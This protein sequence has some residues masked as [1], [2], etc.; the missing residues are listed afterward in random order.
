MA[1]AVIPFTDTSSAR[2]DNG[3]IGA[4]LPPHG[5]LRKRSADQCNNSAS[6]NGDNVAYYSGRTLY[7]KLAPLSLRRQVCPHC[8]R[9]YDIFDDN[10]NTFDQSM[11][12]RTNATTSPPSLPPPPT[13]PRLLP[14]PSQEGNAQQQQQQQQSSSSPSPHTHGQ[15]DVGNPAGLLLCSRGNTLPGFDDGVGDATNSSE[16]CMTGLHPPAAAFTSHYFRALPPPAIMA[17]ATRGVSVPLAIEDY[18]PSLPIDGTKSDYEK[19]RQQLTVAPA[20]GGGGTGDSDDSGET[21]LY[22]VSSSP[23]YSYVNPTAGTRIHSRLKLLQQKDGSEKEMPPMHESGSPMY[24]P[25]S[26]APS[27]SNGY[28][29]HYFKE[30]RQLG[31]GTYGG[32]YLCRH[33]MCGVNLGEFA[34]KKIPVGDKTTYLQSVL[35]EVRILEEVRRHPNVVEYKHSWVEEAQLA[36]FGPP[37]RCL[38]ILMEYASGGSLDTYL[39]RYGNNLSTLAVWYFFLSS[40]A[41]TAH[42]HDKHILHRDLKPQNLLLTAMQDRPPRVLVSDFGTAAVLEENLYDRSGGTGTLEYMAPE[43]FETTASPHSVNERY[44]N[45]H[46]MASD[47]WSLGMVLHYLAFDGTLP[48]RREDGSVNLDKARRSVNARPP[49]MLQLLE[50]MLQLD[51]SKRPSCSDIL[52]SSMVQSIMRI[53]NKDDYS[54]WNLSV[55]QQQQQHSAATSSSGILPLRSRYSPQA[56]GPAPRNAPNITSVPSSNLVNGA[57]FDA[58]HNNSNVVTVVSTFPSR[59]GALHNPVK[60]RNTNSVLHSSRVELL[61]SSMLTDQSSMTAHGVM[62]GSGSGYNPMIGKLSPMRSSSTVTPQPGEK[63][64]RRS[65]VPSCSP[66]PNRADVGAQTDPVV[67]VKK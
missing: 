21:V 24:S 62:G 9:P 16:N 26:M 25:T 15:R 55:Q 64:H 39:E 17:A 23:Y 63:Q 32:V 14:P 28:Y 4:P 11:F 10:K 50:A 58:R 42:L 35:R 19:A 2:V 13:H 18:H 22:N 31:R 47:V 30:L 36:D 56:P 45:H 34:L 29:R 3:D 60:E 44:V 41:G 12:F 43:L 6:D 53:F 51:S 59:G 20:S 5:D 65:H 54:Q 40:V 48:E 27:P 8:L 52:G 38:F 1:L 66:L 61:S 46:T 37:V 7:E 33:M 49:E 67:I 57:P